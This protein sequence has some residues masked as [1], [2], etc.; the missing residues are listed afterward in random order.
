[1]QQTLDVNRPGAELEIE[2][3]LPVVRGSC[4][5]LRGSGGALRARDG[6]VLRAGVGRK[7]GGEDE[8]GWEKRRHA[9]VG[10]GCEAS[11]NTV[12]GPELREA[13]ESVKWLVQFFL[14]STRHQ[15]TTR[16]NVRFTAG[17]RDECRRPG[18]FASVARYS[19]LASPRAA[20]EPAAC[21]RA[22]P[23]PAPADPA[24][25]RSSPSHPHASRLRASARAPRSPD[26]PSDPPTPAPRD[27]ESPPARPSTPRPSRSAAAESTPANP[28]MRAPAGDRPCVT[29]RVRAR[30][31]SSPRCTGRRSPSARARRPPLHAP[32]SSVHRAGIAASANT[33]ADPGA[34]PVTAVGSNRAAIAG[35]L[36][37]TAFASCSF[38]ICRYAYM[39]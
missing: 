30:S 10:G 3:A 29:R 13:P 8:P 37:R 35:R 19:A 23:S 9:S 21:R 6:I 20:Q 16:M 33:P 24:S 22:A 7:N 28:W 39:A 34:A 38:P 12:R 1:M 17:R 25:P 2:V 26:A 5:I 18:S 11:S 36:S 31:T 27:A 15:R 4:R 32:R 14:Y